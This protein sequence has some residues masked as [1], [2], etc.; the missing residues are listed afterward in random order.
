MPYQCDGQGAGKGGGVRGPRSV[1]SGSCGPSG[2]KWG[3]RGGP[4]GP[5]PGRWQGFPLLHTSAG[6]ASGASS[7]GGA[8]STLHRPRA[9][10]AAAAVELPR[11]LAA[12]AAFGAGFGLE[13]TASDRETLT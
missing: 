4:L 3:P 12:S 6:A 9:T 13:G 8:R 10:A 1:V 11:A 7:I 2:T 5:P